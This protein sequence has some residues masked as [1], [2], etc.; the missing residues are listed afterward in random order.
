MS[1]NRVTCSHCGISIKNVGRSWT[2]HY[3]NSPACL[4]SQMEEERRAAAVEHLEPRVPEDDVVEPHAEEDASSPRSDAE[5]NLGGIPGVHSPTSLVG[6]TDAQI[7]QDSDN[8][9]PPETN[10]DCSEDG[11]RSTTSDATESTDREEYFETDP[12]LDEATADHSLQSLQSGDDELEDNED[13][14]HHFGDDELEDGDFEDDLD[15]NYLAQKR[16]DSFRDQPPLDD[17]LSEE[18][19]LTYR[20]LDVLQSSGAPLSCFEKI[21]ELTQHAHKMQVPLKPVT[22]EKALKDLRHRFKQEELSPRQTEL[23]LP[24]GM[25]ATITTID[26]CAAL[27][28]LLSDPELMKD[29]HLLLYEKEDGSAMGRPQEVPPEELVDI[30]DGDVCR[31]AYRLYVKNSDDLLIPIIL[32]IDKTHLDR[33]G[34]LTLEPVCMTLG[35]FKKEYRRHPQFWRTLGFVNTFRGGSADLD[36]AKKVQDYHFV[37]SHILESYKDAQNMELRWMLHYR[38]QSHDVSL[39]MPLLYVIGDTEGH[40]KLCA[41]YQNRTKSNAICRYCQCPSDQTGNPDASYKKTSAK[42][43]A[44]LARRRNLDELKRLSYHCVVNAFNDIKFC[45]PTRGINGATPGELL[46]VFQHGLYQYMHISILTAKREEILTGTKGSK[47]KRATAKEDKQAHAQS[48]VQETDAQTADPD[49]AAEHAE[50]PQHVANSGDAAPPPEYMDD[51]Q[52]PSQKSIWNVF[53]PKLQKEV[54]SAAKKYGEH[55]VHQSDREYHRAYFKGGITSSKSIQG[56]EE[57]M[58]LLLFLILFSCSMF[59]EFKKAFGSEERLS[60]YVLVLSHFIMIEDFMKRDSIS[61]SEVKSLQRYMPRFME[62]FKRATDRNAGMGMNIIKFHLLLHASEDMLRFGPST[63]YDSSFCESM[64]KVYKLDARRTQ[65][66]TDDSFQ[67]QTAK[68]SCERIAIECGMR[69]IRAKEN[70]NKQRVPTVSEVKVRGSRLRIPT[71]ATQPGQCIGETLPWNDWRA[72][73]NLHLD[74]E[75]AV[76]SVADVHGFLFRA[77]WWIDRYDWAYVHW[78][79]FGNVVAR[80]KCFFNLEHGETCLCA[81]TGTTYEGPGCFALAEAF[82][83]D[84][85]RA[86]PDDSSDV[87]FQ[88]HSASA[89][90]YRMELAHVGASECQL[91][92]VDLGTMVK[93]PAAVVPFDLTDDN[94]LE[95]LVVAPKWERQGIFRDNMD[96]LISR[97][98]KRK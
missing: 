26:F 27:G 54:D 40:D 66:R 45:D 24:S 96:D 81:P 3:N 44:N 63:S 32:F 93:G 55:L 92:V 98:R 37:L 36:S 61:R 18:Q 87:N 69:A 33:N 51:F 38:G 49:V 59:P 23:E 53:P 4:E 74:R 67:Y 8:S 43:I 22:R 12:E 91:F 85:T 16:L 52:Q 9:F 5:A 2:L 78:E 86:P 64:H 76:C 30:L 70:R 20:I 80:F 29:E 41:H 56:H 21:V 10:A 88:A 89:L 62:M 68:R 73:S 97:A 77:E 71:E 42:Y 60:L 95:W 48:D 94:P 25:L 34:R 90:L 57:R 82:T 83:Q 11:E 14:D 47:K 58:I 75:V 39:Q 31:E 79:E 46:H 7:M 6:D 15:P 13:D 1:L 28:S 84:Y 72:L 35:I 50:P 17:P 65:K 19:E